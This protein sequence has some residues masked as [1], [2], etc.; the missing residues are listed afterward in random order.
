MLN[1]YTLNSDHNRVS[2]RT[3]VAAHVIDALTPLLVPGRHAIEQVPGYD[4]MVTAGDGLMC[5]VFRGELPLVTFG[6]ADTQP[7]ANEIWGPL[8]EIYATLPGAKARTQPPLPWCA[9]V[10]AGALLP[11]EHA[12]LEWLGDFERCVAWAWLAPRLSH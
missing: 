12:A 7:A 6:V 2:P 5:T 3:E 8:C 11:V 10:I 9:V 4:A 1:H